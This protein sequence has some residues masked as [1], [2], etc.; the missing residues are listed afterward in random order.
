MR[1]SREEA[2]SR[3]MSRGMVVSLESFPVFPRCLGTTALPFLLSFV[4]VVVVLTF[5]GAERCARTSS[6]VVSAASAPSQRSLEVKGL[7]GN[8]LS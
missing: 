1:E 8:V 3:R 7:E 2:I 5:L 4:A 6:S